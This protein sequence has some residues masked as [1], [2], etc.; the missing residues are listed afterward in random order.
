MSSTFMSW[1]GGDLIQLLSKMFLYVY[2]S[3]SRSSSM[4]SLLNITP[5]LR[6]PTWKLHLDISEAFLTQHIQTRTLHSFLTLKYTAFVPPFA[7]NSSHPFNCM[8]QALKSHI[9]YTSF[10][11]HICKNSVRSTIFTYKI[12]PQLN[13]SHQ[14]CCYNSNLFLHQF[15]LPCQTLNSPISTL[16]PLQFHST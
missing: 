9:D 6:L 11:S 13:H 8:D 3:Q 4:A 12:Y 5:F 15:N 7:V 2:A 16:V 14:V 10:M 1:G